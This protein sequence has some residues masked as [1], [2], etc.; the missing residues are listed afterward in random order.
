MEPRDPLTEQVIG[1]AIDVHRELG[2]GL[3]E[4]AYQICLC[5]ELELRHIEHAYEV[6]IPVLYKG[7]KIDCGYRLD[8]V[9]PGRLIV[10]TKAVEKLLP[11]PEAQLITYLKLTGI[12]LGLLLNFNVP[13]LKNG[14]K[15]LIH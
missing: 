10:E 9:I 7:I 5:R 14:I 6:E 3:L 15:R 13:V 11:I 1:A 12:R 2:P 8:I 4:S